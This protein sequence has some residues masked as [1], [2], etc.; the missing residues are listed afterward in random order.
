MFSEHDLPDMFV[1]NKTQ[2]IAYFR[3]KRKYA[4]LF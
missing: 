3:V 1:I 2:S 4:M